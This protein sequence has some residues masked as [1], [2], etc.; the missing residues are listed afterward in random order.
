MKNWARL[1]IETKDAINIDVK[2]HCFDNT[3]RADVFIEG[4]GGIWTF[5]KDEIFSQ[6]WVDYVKETCPYLDVTMQFYCL[7]CCLNTLVEF[8]K[9]CP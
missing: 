3:D 9:Y 1:D 8:L 4:H 5:G 6:D 7:Y 2:K